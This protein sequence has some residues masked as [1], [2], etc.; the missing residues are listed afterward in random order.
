[1][2]IIAAILSLLAIAIS[3]ATAADVMA[4]FPPAEKG[5]SRHVIHLARQANEDDLKVELIIGK[6]VTTDSINKYFFAGDLATESIPGWG[7]DRYILR[8]LGP[9]AGTMIAV[10]ADAPRIEHF[11]G[12]GGEQK[13]LRYNS[14]LPL[15]VYVPADVEVRYRLWR[16]ERTARQAHRIALPNGGTAVVA[17]ATM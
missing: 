3:T 11:V 9:M 8:K 14:R 5:M 13:L 10:P 16:A 15:V 4:A 6:T 1:M 2:K 12:L 7:F 17:R